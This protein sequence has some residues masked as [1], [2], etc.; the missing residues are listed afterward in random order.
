MSWHF[1]RALVE[2]YSEACCS[3]GEPSALLKSTRTP[4]AY[5]WPDKTTG[6]S[7]LS[8]FGMTSEPLTESRG[9]ELLTWFLEG[10]RVRT[11]QS[12]ARGQDSP[13]S[14]AD[15]G[16]KWRA[17][18]ARYSRDSRSWKTAQCSLLEG[19]DEFSETWPKW[20]LT[21]NGECSERMTWE[22]PTYESESGF[23]PTPQGKT[24]EGR[25][26]TVCLER[27][28]HEVRRG[29]WPTPR[30]NDGQKRGDFDENNPRNG[31]AGAVK[32]WP[33]PNASDG[34]KWSA[35]TKQERQAK[36]QQV[37]LCHELG[38][39]GRL[40]PQWVEWLMGWPIGWTDLQPLETDRF[41]E[42]LAQHGGF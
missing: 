15:C 9:A 5:Y 2:E 1:S 34:A 42:W 20:G 26:Q 36:G 39:G 3:G 40:N 29:N 31:L 35:Q 25:K 38:A 14:A 11:F 37:R 24:P 6:H 41:R 32:K 4:A 33:T 19:L 16:R 17:S 12:E 30:A 13:A 23:W 18:F 10:F 28:V 8:R 21:R 22:R 27:Y 7:R